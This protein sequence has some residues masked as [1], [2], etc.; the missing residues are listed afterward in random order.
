MGL[1]GQG[2]VARLAHGTTQTRGHVFSGD[3]G[4]P[5]RLRG[6][7]HIGIH[8]ARNFF[9]R[10]LHP[11]DARG[12]RHAANADV[13]SRVNHRR[14]FHV[15]FPVHQIRMHGLPFE[16]AEVKMQLMLRQG[17]VT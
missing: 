10:T 16:V 2:L 11:A 3:E 13:Q 9:K 7:I 4:H 8:D 15:R 14:F 12:A 1:G 6:Q 5:G 17:G